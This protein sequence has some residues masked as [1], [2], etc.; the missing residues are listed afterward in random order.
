MNAYQII[1][2]MV[3]VVRMMLEL[4][5]VDHVRATWQEMEQFVSVSVV[6]KMIL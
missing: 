2:T 1:A 4:L 3:S 5:N 6:R